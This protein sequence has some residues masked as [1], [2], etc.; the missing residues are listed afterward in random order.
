MVYHFFILRIRKI[1][2]TENISKLL[3]LRELLNADKKIKYVIEASEYILVI[4]G[5]YFSLLKL[6]IVGVTETKIL[7]EIIHYSNIL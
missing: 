3:K 5:C 6:K 7:R 1:E 2:G 4:N